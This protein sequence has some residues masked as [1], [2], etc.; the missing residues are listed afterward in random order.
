MTA[1]N[2]FYLFRFRTKIDTALSNEPIKVEVAYEW[3]PPSV[4]NVKFMG[5]LAYLQNMHR[6]WCKKPP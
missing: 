6:H 1:E 2:G 3:K 4:K 5:T